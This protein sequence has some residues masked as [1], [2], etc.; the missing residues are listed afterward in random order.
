MAEEMDKLLAR[1]DIRVIDFNRDG[2]V[3]FGDFCSFLGYMDANNPLAD[4]APMPFGDDTVNV[5]DVAAFAEY[6]LADVLAFAHWRLD[7]AEG[8]V[9]YDA[10]GDKDGTLHGGPSWRVT[11][12]RVGGSLEFDG[13][14]DYVGAD[15]VLDPADGPFSVYAWIK[16]GGGQQVVISQ[17]NGGGIGWS[18]LCADSAG[19]LMT[20]LRSLAG[21]QFGPPL[22]S[23]FAITDGDWRRIGLVWD[24]TYRCLY[25]DGAEVKRDSEPQPPL[26]S[27]TGGL[28]LGVASTLAPGTHWLGLIDDVRIY[29]TVV[30]QP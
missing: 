20:D 16:G 4:I 19:N 30:I 1:K 3:N 22:V 27:A 26:T 11:G 9:A 14:D 23:D 24:G 10:A 17:G 25:V 13:I 5:L 12:G 7:E 8:D 6:W 21:R 29:D 15:Y 2:N 18:W 28:S